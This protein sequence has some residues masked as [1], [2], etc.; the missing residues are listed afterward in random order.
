MD[1]VIGLPK[2][3]HLQCSMEDFF[4]F[5]FVI[6]S[7]LTAFSFSS[8][9]P[10]VFFPFLYLGQA[11]PPDLQDSA[12]L[13]LNSYS[14]PHW[15]S[16]I[17]TFLSTSISTQSSYC[18]ALFSLYKFILKEKSICK[19]LQSVLAAYLSHILFLMFMFEVDFKLF[20]GRAVF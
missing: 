8:I 13:C 20:G 10:K 7:V 1:T 6:R 15:L 14:F 12:S 17:L 3:K 5:C 19:I 11:L 4:Y 18:W 16:G 2:D 9:P